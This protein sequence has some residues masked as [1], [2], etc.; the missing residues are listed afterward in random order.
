MIGDYPWGRSYQA[1]ILE[2]DQA[3]MTKCIQASEAEI[4]AR[5]EQLN[6]DHG[7]ASEERQSI[8]DALSGLHMLRN[9][10]Q[11]GS[12]DQFKRDPDK[13][14]SEWSGSRGSEPRAN[15]SPYGERKPERE[16]SQQ[17]T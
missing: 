1:A 12:Q 6:S 9:E 10:L 8:R 15:A 13:R 5:V 17:N 11:R 2:T 16:T 7:G 4:L 14:D 3:R